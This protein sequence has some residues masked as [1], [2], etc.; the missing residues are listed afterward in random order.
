VIDRKRGEPVSVVGS[1][2]MTGIAT[3]TMTAKTS[4]TYSP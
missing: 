1:G 4:Y 2:P 3:G